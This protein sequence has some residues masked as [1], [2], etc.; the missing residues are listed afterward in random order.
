MDLEREKEITNEKVK[1]I[2][3]SLFDISV[4][5]IQ[6]EGLLRE[7]YELDSINLVNFQIEIEDY[8]EIRFDPVIEDLGEVFRS[9]STL[10]DYIASYTAK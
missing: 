2:F 7:D 1:Q 3:S 6:E 10:S 5:K 4:E 8:F 9:I